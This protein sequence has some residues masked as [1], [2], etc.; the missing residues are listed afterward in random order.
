[1]DNCKYIGRWILG[2]REVSSEEDA[3]YIAF[4][5]ARKEELEKAF[6]ND[7]IRFAV[8]Y[9]AL[10]ERA[11]DEAAAKITE[12]KNETEQFK[13]RADDAIHKQQQLQQQTDQA[14]RRQQQLSE[15]NKSLKKQADDVIRAQAQCY[16]EHKLFE[17]LLRETRERANSERKIKGGKHHSGYVGISSTPYFQRYRNG[18]S[19]YEKWTWKTV[20][21]TPYKAS[22]GVIAVDQIIYD[23]TQGQ[24]IKGK[25]VEP[26]LKR[27]GTRY[28]PLMPTEE[29]KVYGE[30]EVSWETVRSASIANN[31]EK[32]GN[33]CYNMEFSADLKRDFW[34]LTLYTTEMPDLHELVKGRQES[35]N[36]DFINH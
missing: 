9:R 36:V 22:L 2:L 35:D 34:R 3:V 33:I 7:E 19:T 13:A 14:V 31:I 27:I 26:L 18:V 24:T 21:E 17:S 30:H 20:I 29:E 12:A 15:E 32:N 23:V 16:R 11:D 8:M 25:K 6:Q 5:I 4:D 1:M 28:P 10:K